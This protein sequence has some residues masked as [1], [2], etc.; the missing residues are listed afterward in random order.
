LITGNT[1]NTF[2]TIHQGITLPN[3]DTVTG[4][5]AVT[6]NSGYL[7]W[8]TAADTINARNVSVA[9]PNLSNINYYIPLS[10]IT[11]GSVALVTSSSFYYTNGVLNVTAAS[12]FYADLAERYAADA[13][14]D[15]GTVLVIG[16]EK[17]VTVTTQFA[18]TRVAGVVSKNPA[19]LMNKDAG[20]NET[21][22]AIALKGRVP[23]KVVGYVKKG[24]LI[25]TSSTPG[26]GTA[27]AS[28][29]AGAVIGKALGTQSEGFGIIEI[30][31]V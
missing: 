14:Y 20:N 30:L 18:D 5:S 6:T 21:H 11:T 2:T 27:A 26:Y 16:G 17:E 24:D 8:G 25:V 1:L 10:N 31:I 9:N 3:A 22:P 13:A 4:V 19:Y 29:V 28:V 12:A 23:C 7:L 15:E